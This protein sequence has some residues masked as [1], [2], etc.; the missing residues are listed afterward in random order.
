MA[1]LFSAFS[2]IT[3]W[4][5]LGFTQLLTKKLL[6]YSKVFRKRQKKCLK[7]FLKLK[8]SRYDIKYKRNV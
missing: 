7:C 5:K 6:K 2:W 4:R 3:D 1:I 8:L